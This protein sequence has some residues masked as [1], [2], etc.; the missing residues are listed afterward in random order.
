MN[1]E[2]F[3]NLSFYAHLA[4]LMFILFAVYFVISNF[5]YLEN[6]SAEKKIYVV[7][8]FSI[9]SGVHGL[10]HLGLE[11]LYQYNPMGFFVRTVHSLM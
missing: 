9:A 1:L 10:S 3:L 5:S 8:L 11:N 7:L 4:N 2:V 6:M